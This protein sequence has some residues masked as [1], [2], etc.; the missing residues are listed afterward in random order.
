MNALLLAAVF[1]FLHPAPRQPQADGTAPVAQVKVTGSKRFAEADIAKACGLEPGKLVSR[2]DLQ[3]AADRLSALGWFAKVSY[4]FH[5]VAK[6]VDVQF[7]IEDA[8]T[9]P[10]WFDNFPW[11]T[12]Q[13]IG[14]AIHDAAVLYDGT[15]PEGGTAL[16]AMRDA[17]EGLLKKEGIL[18]TVEGE[19]IQAPGEDA[20]I[21]RFRVTGPDTRVAALE[22][23]DAVAQQDAGLQQGLN[24][25]V[26][27]PYS[28]YLLAIFVIEKV[29]PLYS[30]H[31]FL[32]AQVGEPQSRFSGDPHKP[33]GNQV[34]VS[35]PIHPGVQ[36]RWGG[37]SWKGQTAF[38]E[39]AL[40]AMLG[41][42]PGEPVDGVRL[43]GVWERI[44]GE[45]SQRG[46]LDAKIELT[47]HFDDAAGRVSYDVH[48]AEG[49][50]YR[51]GQI[52]VTG[53]SL[54]AERQL[55]SNWKIA[56]GDV[57]NKQFV[58]DFVNSGARKLFENTPV[59]F[60]RVGHLLRP[61]PATHT[62]DVLLDFQ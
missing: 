26:G 34:Y 52:V 9:V 27:Q 19:L 5:T 22:F 12:D 20:M 2:A 36:Y 57:F 1:L 23:G 7:T 45:Y 48:I 21:E 43:Q 51:M 32:R 35:L 41:V 24:A 6:G 31:G 28:R 17:L 54:A 37:A 62:V 25:V 60:V 55:L 44:A 47:S 10:V 42:A 14:K 33:L 61:N 39:A 11:F 3:A 59:H 53:L 4:T 58:E 18:G 29:R 30:A 56:R 15:A 16:D 46:Y 38:D 50:Q 49:A 40:N 8:P 13:E